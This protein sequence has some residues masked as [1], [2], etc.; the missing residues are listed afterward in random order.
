MLSLSS[1][2]VASLSL[3]SGI[4]ITIISLGG[5]N[6]SSLTS[7]SFQMPGMMGTNMMGISE[8]DDH[9]GAASFCAACNKNDA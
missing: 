9:A 3:I 2:S 8:Y 5:I 6:A 4:I 1:L 7:Y